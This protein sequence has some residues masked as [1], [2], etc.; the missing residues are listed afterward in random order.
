MWFHKHVSTNDN[1]NLKVGI[2]VK[3][4][5]ILQ[6]LLMRCSMAVLSRNQ[7][8]M[9]DKCRPQ[10]DT[11]GTTQSFNLHILLFSLVLYLTKF[12]KYQNSQ[13]LPTWRIG[14]IQSSYL[15][16]QSI[17]AKEYADCISAEGY[18]SLNECPG[19]DTK[20][21]DDE[22]TVMQSTSLL[23]LLPGP[24]WS[25]VVAPNRIKLCIYAKLNCL[26]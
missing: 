17:R 13:I 4:I 2:L 18:N 10:E 6:K 3:P 16:A 7:D 5:C 23:P 20:Q 26:K 12:I 14:A 11:L 21:S 25:R 9:S 1:K 15:L 19:Y 22:A 8:G 24:I